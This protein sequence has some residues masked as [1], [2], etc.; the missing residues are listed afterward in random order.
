MMCDSV[1]LSAKA[2]AEIVSVRQDRE[3]TVRFRYRWN[4]GFGPRTA[5]APLPL[6][7]LNLRPLA[8]AA[9]VMPT[10]DRLALHHAQLRSLALG[11]RL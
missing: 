4:T 1:L 10:S 7:G 8:S 11:S 3:D 9:I 5:A 6:L 2:I